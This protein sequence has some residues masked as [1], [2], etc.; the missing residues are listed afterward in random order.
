[1]CTPDPSDLDLLLHRSPTLYLLPLQATAHTAA[2]SSQPPTALEAL[3]A[4]K[5][6]AATA[7]KVKA[8]APVVMGAAVIAAAQT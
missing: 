1:M 7:L 3:D 2:A 5:V 4:L 6:K 8:V